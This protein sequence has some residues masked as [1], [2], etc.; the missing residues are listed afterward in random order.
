MD[1]LL[2]KLSSKVWLVALIALLASAVTVYKP[3]AA[4]T[5]GN[6][7][8]VGYDYPTG[9]YHYCALRVW[10]D[11]KNGS[12]VDVSNHSYVSDL[13]SLD[14]QKPLTRVNYNTVSGSYTGIGSSMITY[15]GRVYVTFK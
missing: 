4:P 2:K 7:Y 8:A 13:L 12:L 1:A 3:L 11:F 9:T 15:S 5:T 14:G 10:A 6:Y